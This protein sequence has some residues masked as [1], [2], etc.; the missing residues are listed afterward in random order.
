M[1]VHKEFFE[2]GSDM[3]ETNTFTSTSISLA[4]YALVVAL[5]GCWQRQLAIP[6]NNGVDFRS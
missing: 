4:D 1:A 5:I 2:A 6:R 3:I